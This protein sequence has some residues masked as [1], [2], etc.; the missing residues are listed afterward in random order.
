MKPNDGSTSKE[1][2]PGD[3]QTEFPDSV[4]FPPQWIVGIFYG[5]RWH[6]VEEGSF[7]EGIDTDHGPMAVYRDPFN[8]DAVFL[9]EPITGFKVRK[10]EPPPEPKASVTELYPKK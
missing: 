10:P 7:R 5:G 2:S 3:L 4:Y 1:S 8:K 9:V 6:D